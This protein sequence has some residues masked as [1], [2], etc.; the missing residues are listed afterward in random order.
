MQM[1]IHHLLP[2]AFSN[3]EGYFVAGNPLLC[4]KFLRFQNEHPWNVFG[5]FRD[6]RDR[7]NEH[8]WN[9]EEMGRRFWMNIL[10]CE[11]LGVFVDDVCGDFLVS[12][13]VEDCFRF[14]AG[15]L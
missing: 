12:D 13:A 9:E 14:H 8:F 10:E 5:L 7:C 2:S 4:C 1:K 11:D 6:I 3:V 15:G